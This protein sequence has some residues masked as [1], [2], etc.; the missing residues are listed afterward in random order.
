MIVFQPRGCGVRGSEGRE[1]M[2]KRRKYTNNEGEEKE[3][4][5]REKK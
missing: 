4:S 3:T 5:Q 1:N 2:K